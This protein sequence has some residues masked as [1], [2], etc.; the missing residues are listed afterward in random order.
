MTALV[1]APPSPPRIDA[2]QA[3][4]LAPMGRDAALLVDA[5]RVAGMHASAAANPVDLLTLVQADVAGDNDPTLGA[6]IAT[7][8]AL[9]LEWSVRLADA[10]E[11][12]PS[13]SDLPI[14]LLGR[15]PAFTMHVGRAASPPTA[16]IAER[17]TGRASVTVLDRPVRIAALVSAVRAA[18]RARARQA[19]VR[20]LIAARTRA[21]AEAEH[22]NMAK[23]DFLAVM[24]HEL[25]T[26]LNAIAGYAD[27]L[28]AGCYG[29][30]SA[31]Q[32]E[33]LDRIMR[34]ERHLLGIINDLLNYARLE[35]G[36]VEY[37]IERVRIADVLSEVKPLVEPQVVAKR[38]S[39]D[40][41]L[42]AIEVEV[43][44]DR[45]K[46]RQVVLNL[47]SNAV[48]FTRP[49]GSILVET[50]ERADGTQPG[51][52]V[53][54]RVCDSGIG[55]PE[56]KLEAVF[57]PFVQVRSSDGVPREGTGLGLAISRDLIR[58]MGG[59]LRARSGPAGSRFTVELRRPESRHD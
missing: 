41:R 37:R 40:V 19:Q 13:W 18:L 31:D 32:Q 36:R 11:Q 27:L 46:L 29:A 28:S 56:D 45:E 7:D 17:L 20:E 1:D 50:A 22:A 54:L 14:L 47:L 6:V 42:P 49:G 58:G 21:Q 24:S 34:A 35:K 43:S 48:K 2:L 38:L 59:E 55:I 57:E 51:D 10:L 52:R 3:V 9:G 25:R 8:E 33:A 53:F 4:V 5:L 16:P 39:C 26:P 12:Q 30:L 15:S 23:S 44:A